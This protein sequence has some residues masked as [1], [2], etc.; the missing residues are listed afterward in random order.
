MLTACLL[1]NFATAWYFTGLIWWVQLVSYPT[2]AHIP[3]QAWPTA[4][5]LHVR[6]AGMAVVVPMLLEGMAAIGL[7]I[8]LEGGSRSIA[9]LAL[10]ALA[11]VWISTFGLQVPLHSRLSRGHNP[12]LIERLVIGNLLRAVL[13]TA[14]GILA[15]LLVLPVLK[16]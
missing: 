15:V 10:I 3:P 7:V 16:A 12:A 5:A 1:I 9:W 6:R 8:L 2:L 4:H 11:G 14:R 13:W